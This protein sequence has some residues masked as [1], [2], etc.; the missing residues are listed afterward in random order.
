MFK[1]DENTNLYTFYNYLFERIDSNLI[2]LENNK[3]VLG[4]AE[5]KWAELHVENFFIDELG[6]ETKI[7]GSE[8]ANWEELLLILQ[9]SNNENAKLKKQIDNL[10]ASAEGNTF[11]YETDSSVAF[12]KNVPL[13]ASPYATI[14]K[15]GGMS[16][17]VDNEI[18]D[19]KVTAIKSVGAN[20]FNI[21]DQVIKNNNVQIDIHNGL[22][23]FSGKTLSNLEITLAFDKPFP[24]GTYSLTLFNQSKYSIKEFDY[25]FIDEDGENYGDTFNYKNNEYITY[26]IPKNVVGIYFYFS[27]KDIDVGSLTMTPMITR[28]DYIP[29]E[30][31]NYFELIKGISSDIQNL[32]GYDLGVNGINYNYVDYFNKT[33]TQKTNK[34]R[35]DNDLIGKYFDGKI[36]RILLNSTKDSNGNETGFYNFKIENFTNMTLR[37]SNSVTGDVVQNS[38]IPNETHYQDYVNLKYEQFAIQNNN[39]YIVID[40]NKASNVEEFTTWLSN[41]PFDLVYILNTP[42]ITDISDLLEDDEFIEVEGNGTLEFVNEHS[43][44]CGSEVT[45]EVKLL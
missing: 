16:Y 17:V 24:A 28:N 19:S 2:P 37:A 1:M 43:Q 32:D 45:Y 20:L 35:I 41:N 13:T 38:G 11:D 25:G 18:R 26:D 14:D 30:F 22:F 23:T 33:Y 4:T 10:K 6:P 5:N 21:Q 29:S 31:K 15:V 9:I 39:L 42:I 36:C 8:V 44:A 34:T 7:R 12:V 3:N 27:T 40:K